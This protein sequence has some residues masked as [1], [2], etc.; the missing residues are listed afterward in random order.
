M[1]TKYDTSAS[2]YIGITTID[3]LQH[4]IRSV[5]SDPRRCQLVILVDTAISE[6]VFDVGS[7]IKALKVARCGSSKHC[8][9]PLL[10]DGSSTFNKLRM[11][12]WE[13][14]LQRRARRTQERSLFLG[15]DVC[16]QIDMSRASS[17]LGSVETLSPDQRDRAAAHLEQMQNVD[18]TGSWWKR[19]KG[20]VAGLMG[21]LSGGG[22]FAGLGGFRVM[23]RG[24]YVSFSH[25]ST[26]LSAGY[27]S[28]KASGLVMAVGGAALVG[29][30]VGLVI[31]FM[32]WETF[33]SYT[34]DLFQKVWGA[35][36][37]FWNWL[38]AKWDGLLDSFKQW[39][40]NASSQGTEKQHHSYGSH[41]GLQ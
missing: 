2:S 4:E 5:R 13:E 6:I 19:W 10:I 3:G 33:F 22:M 20:P 39:R 24:M 31:Y 37:P 40:E 17:Y 35:V 7:N 34:R 11:D 16:I 26:T 1:L 25:G 27:G 15:P 18:L 28:L 9:R 21:I 23:A 32:P 12:E 29:A 14:G 38:V 41:G 36:K 8:H 30:G